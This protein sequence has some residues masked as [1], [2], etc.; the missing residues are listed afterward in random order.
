MADVGL[1][2]QIFE[3]L[4]K[5]NQPA[6]VADL[7]LAAMDG[8]D[9][10][11]AALGGAVPPRPTITP[12]QL[13][14][15]PVE[16]AYLTSIAVRSFRGIGPEA[17]LDLAPGPGLTVVHG[18]NGSGKSSFA[19]GLEIA[20]TGDA[21]R[22]TRGT[23]KVWRDGWKN[24]HGTESPR[25]T[26]GML[27]P[28][29]KGTCTL[30]REWS[31]DDHMLSKTSVRR[32][33][34]PNVE[35]E[36]LGWQQ[37]LGPMRPI[38]ASAEI[39]SL[40]EQTPSELS[41]RLGAILGLEDVVAASG[42]LKDQLAPIKEQVKARDD[43]RKSARRA[44]DDVDDPRATKVRTLLGK[45]TVPLDEVTFLAET[46]EGIDPAVTDLVTIT[47]IRAPDFELIGHAASELRRTA[48]ELRGLDTLGN[49]QARMT[50]DVLIKA[51]DWHEHTGGEA[52]PVCGT[53]EVL[54]DE[55]RDRTR[56]LINQLRSSASALTAAE[57]AF[58]SAI[59][60]ARG[61]CASPT[62]PDPAVATVAAGELS[63]LWSRWAQTIPTQPAAAAVDEVAR[64]FEETAIDVIHM[65]ESVV[66]AARLEID[67]R[68]SRWRGAAAVVRDYIV[69]ARG[70][71]TADDNAQDLSAARQWLEDAEQ[72][73][74]NERLADVR[75]RACRYWDQLRQQSSIE[76][77]DYSVTGKGTHQRVSFDVVVDGVKSQALGVMSQ[78]ELNALA[79]S[80]FLP[81]A[82]QPESPFRFCVIDDPVQAM[83]P[84]KVNG[85]ARV[86]S[87]LAVERQVVVF[88]HDL[89]LV[90]ALEHLRIPATIL[91]VVRSEGSEVSVM[92]MRDPVTQ[93][94]D[95]AAAIVCDP[96][97]PS[98]V[99]RRVVPNLCR[100]A[101]EEALARRYRRER[102][103]LGGDPDTVEAALRSCEGANPLAA[104][105]LCDG[106]EHGAD[107]LK[108]INRKFGVWAG[109]AFRTVKEHGH[110]G[111]ATESAARDLIDPAAR[112]CR[113]L[114]R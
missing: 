5:A 42:R 59:A 40:I 6:R 65:H 68:E 75:V 69:L 33:S 82:T 85:L 23:S 19:E 21:H 81:R 20:L 62:I 39:E 83:D 97:V 30:T 53:S 106:K 52:C 64:A 77:T 111:T 44:L 79:L 56:G 91:E 92:E 110:S 48:D 74:R 107:V 46:T 108:T 34:L 114:A 22:F 38:C 45:R 96:E 9:Q 84:A 66:A 57:T 99:I 1:I 58:A 16:G 41:R 25:V 76:L 71:A 49:R 109:D 61:Q 28:G 35:I 18:G 93:F 7:V 101:V 87:E 113:V 112:L 72:A 2:E 103:T 55:W 4:V 98:E 3:R 63:S 67:S 8:D 86:L 47:T 94:L 105:V 102:L 90:D 31:S 13:T 11:V 70:A 17:K 37:V 80:I 88:T 15:N 36:A 100:Q 32:P 51:L 73:M 29:H 26:V 12:Q 50:V 24:L 95:D 60:T 78:G 104:L 54:N 14:S 89:R 43:A 27:L 10:L